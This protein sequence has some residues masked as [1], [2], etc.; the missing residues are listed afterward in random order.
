MPAKNA[1]K[2][3]P[4]I[5]LGDKFPLDAEQCEKVIGVPLDR[6]PGQCT[7]VAH[8]FLTRKL[9][10]KGM[11]E[12]YGMWHGVIAQGSPFAGRPMARHGWLRTPVTSGQ[13]RSAVVVIDPTRWV[14]EGVKPY[15]YQGVE[16][17]EYDEG[18]MAL[19]SLGRGPPPSPVIAAG[20]KTTS[21][22][23]LETGTR[24]AKAALKWVRTFFPEAP[25]FNQMQLGWLANMPP[26]E[27][28]E[29]GDHAAVI[30][31]A[32]DQAGRKTLVPIDWWRA[33]ERGDLGRLW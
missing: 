33:F 26:S 5:K 25:V 23:V 19:R 4:R 3:E 21:L 29:H 32:M 18:M 17:A 31:Q 24:K 28:G 20:E 12:V 30:Y 22:T 11:V 14:F 10:P 15:V 13:D 1:R 6:W 8:L 27:M 16:G 9:A 7:L 2:Q